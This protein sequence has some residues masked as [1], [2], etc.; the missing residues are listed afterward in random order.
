MIVSYSFLEVRYKLTFLV[1]LPGNFTVWLASPAARFL[2]GKFVAANWDVDE[3]KEK[4][5]EIEST[6]LLA[7]GLN[8]LASW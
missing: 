7:M 2:K 8:G 3:L 6:T 1:D 5:E 4:A